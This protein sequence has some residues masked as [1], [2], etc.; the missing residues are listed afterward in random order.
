LCY[1]TCQSHQLYNPHNI[2]WTIQDMRILIIVF[3]SLIPL[4]PS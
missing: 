1:T 3:S 4:P 2:L